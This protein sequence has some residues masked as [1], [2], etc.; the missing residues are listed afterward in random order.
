MKKNYGYLLY[1]ISIVQS[2]KKMLMHFLFC[3]LFEDKIN[4]GRVAALMYIAY[5]IVITVVKQKASSLP[6]LLK[7]VV[8]HVVRF[9]KEKLARWIA[10][11]GGW[12]SKL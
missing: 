1:Y 6:R 2:K 11:Q 9:I 12:V 7:I 4:W 3:R 5:L 10:S 8:S